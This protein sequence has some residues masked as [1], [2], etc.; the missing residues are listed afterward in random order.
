[1]T[2]FKEINSLLFGIFLLVMSS[3]VYF[4]FTQTRDFMAN[5]MESDLNNTVTSLSLMLKPHLETGDIVTAETL[6]N[7]IFEG[8]FYQQVKVTWL[9]DGQE[10]VWQNPISIKGVPDWF[11]GLALF[12]S[13]SKEN[14]IT[15]GW[16]Q[17]AKIEVH[18]HPGFAYQ[19]L[20][21][22]M[23]DTVMTLSLLFILS[24]LFVRFRLN[25]IL[26][27]LNEIAEKARQI[28]SKNFT[29]QLPPPKA[30]ELQDVVVAINTMS[31]GLDS[32]FSTLDGE[33][34]H[35]K[36]EKLIDHTANLP[37]RQYFV[38]QTNS[39]LS[40]PGAG[41]LMLA[42]FEWLE[43]IY[44]QYG[45]QGRDEIIKTLATALKQELPKITDTIVARIAANEFAILLTHAEKEEIE[46]SLQALIRL[47]NQEVI[48]AQCHA[49]EDFYIGISM[50]AEQT[51]AADLMA[52][53]DNALQQAALEKK[54]SVWAQVG[55][56]QHL[57]REQ[58]RNLL[59]HA[60]NA[61]A[62]NF[63]SQPVK[64][65]NNSQVLH[66]ELY[67]Q[68]NVEDK[69]VSAKEFMPFVD[70]LALGPLLDKS[71]LSA[72]LQHNITHKVE[73][74]L[75]INLTMASITN[76]AFLTWFGNFLQDVDG[77]KMMF[78]LPETA[79]IAHNE[80][81]L[82]AIKMIKSAGAKVGIDQCGRQIGSLDYLQV[83]KPDYIK[84]DQSFAF[85]A[86]Q[87]QH[88]ELCRAV[89]NIAKSLA[90]EVIITGIE[91]Q[92][93]LAQFTAIHADGYQGY[94]SPLSEV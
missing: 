24:V 12:E 26:F 21:R 1:M 87:S 56:K 63:L 41:A 30:T 68:L 86:S 34:A 64:A 45:F 22:V 25:R 85:L 46:L 11:V 44:Q 20:W 7:V 66:Q 4:Q 40:E 43:R 27:P 5:Q 39:W 79:V 91:N 90:I 78:E 73:H 10:Q 81:C 14:T 13:Q 74:P 77:S 55:Q 93:Q 70:F 65:M 35:L 82:S 23:N 53:A 48:K 28:A 58:W 75:A 9:A 62:F 50:R 92:Q 61:K 3:L 60:I 72:I 37:N 88:K 38:A 42:R 15:S 8:G 18:G 59:H 89:I 29:G 84:L 67:C 6:V 47:V 17:L 69:R 31:S 51:Q 76:E 16:L 71:I 52:Q 2:L 19:E 32:M 33:L 57:N 80:R 94:I 54:V 83:I 49:N 36:E